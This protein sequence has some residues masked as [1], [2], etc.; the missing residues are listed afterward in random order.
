[1]KCGVIIKGFPHLLRTDRQKT[2]RFV[3][4]IV[5][6]TLEICAKA[7]DITVGVPG[8]SFNLYGVKKKQGNTVSENEYHTPSK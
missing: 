1:M 3:V 5:V 2:Y 8:C 4:P 7:Y 6:V